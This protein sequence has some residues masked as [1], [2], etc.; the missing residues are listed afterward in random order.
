MLLASIAE[1]MNIAF[2]AVVRLASPAEVRS[3]ASLVKVAFAN[4]TRPALFTFDAGDKVTQVTHT[5]LHA[6]AA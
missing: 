3:F 1:K 4:I 5:H 2:V 6:T